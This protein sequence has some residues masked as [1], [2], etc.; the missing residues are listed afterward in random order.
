MRLFVAIRFSSEIN[1]ALLSAISELK[2]QVRHGTFTRPE[3]LH[4]TLAFLG[5]TDRITD[6]VSALTA[7]AAVQMGAFPLALAGTGRFGELFW[8]GVAA[9][10]ALSALAREVAVRLRRQGFTIERREFLPHITL[11]RRIDGNDIRITIPRREMIVRDVSLMKS[12]RIEGRLTYTELS[13]V[14][15]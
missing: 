4:L 15:L 11:A 8:A 13:R 1:Q 12:E 10:P 3:N 7:A 6:A 14:S 9:S 5:E 2:Q